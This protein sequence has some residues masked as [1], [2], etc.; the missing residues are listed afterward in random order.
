MTI[1]ANSSLPEIWHAA[2]SPSG[3]AVFRVFCSAAESQIAPLRGL[4][5]STAKEQVH[6]VWPFVCG[7][8]NL[9]KKSQLN[10]ETAV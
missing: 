10:C 4:A 3:G 2:A 8:T 6:D 9:C 7:N 5:P 1:S